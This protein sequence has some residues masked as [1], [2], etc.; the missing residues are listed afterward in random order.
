[1]ER[2]LQ[3]FARKSMWL[4]WY[5][6]FIRVFFFLLPLSSGTACSTSTLIGVFLAVT[7]PNSAP[8]SS[9]VCLHCLPLWFLVYF[10]PKQS[11]PLNSS[12]VLAPVLPF[13]YAFSTNLCTTLSLYFIIISYCTLSRST[14]TGTGLCAERQKFLSKQNFNESH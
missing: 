8:T 10:H 3:M 9:V 6:W 5:T 11:L 12:H 1:M 14:R 7:T 4:K 13:G 2:P